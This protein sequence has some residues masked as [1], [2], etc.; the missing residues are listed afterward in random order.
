MWYNKPKHISVLRSGSNCKAVKI[1]DNAPSKKAKLFCWIMVITLSVICIL[2]GLTEMKIYR[3]LKDKCTSEVTGTVVYEGVGRIDDTDK[4]ENKY[5]SGERFRQ[6]EVE[7][8]GKFELKNIYARRG[9]EKKNDKIHKV[10]LDS[11]T[12]A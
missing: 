9:A 10:Q 6:I 2:T 7:T 11:G 8:D 12:G 3:S 5:V 4:A 1:L